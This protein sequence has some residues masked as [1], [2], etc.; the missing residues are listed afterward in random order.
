MKKEISV[1]FKWMEFKDFFAK[2][3][4]HLA[5]IHYE[6]GNRKLLV[7]KDP[8]KAL[9]HFDNGIRYLPSDESLLLMRGI[10]RY[11]LGDEEGARRDWDRM[12][13]LKNSEQELQKLADQ[14]FGLEGYEGLPWWVKER[15]GAMEP[16]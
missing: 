16:R 11:Q 9:K 12:A 14:L 4:R 6:K 13:T 3:F 8:Q 1:A 7:K 10:C 15:A 5:K 2:D